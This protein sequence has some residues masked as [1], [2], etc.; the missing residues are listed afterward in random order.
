MLKVNIFPVF[1]YCLFFI[2]M[3]II[4]QIIDKYDKEVLLSYGIS[5]N[6]KNLLFQ[7]ENILI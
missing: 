6:Q 7:K 3:V 5:N 1:I 4:I 2:E